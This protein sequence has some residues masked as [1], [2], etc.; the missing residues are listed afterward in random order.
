MFP[1]SI[2]LFVIAH[3]SEK[4]IQT[5]WDIIGQGLTAKPDFVKKKN[6]NLMKKMIFHFLLVQ[7]RFSFPFPVFQTG[8]I[9]LRTFAKPVFQET[10]LDG[11][12]PQKARQFIITQLGSMKRE[13]A[14]LATLEPGRNC[15]THVWWFM[16]YDSTFPP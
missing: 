3:F 2:D 16:N 13:C 1:I 4:K 7:R 8:S 9:M 11:N 14:C 6:T 5:L 15:T 10:N 12:L